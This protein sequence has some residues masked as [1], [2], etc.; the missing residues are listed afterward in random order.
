MKSIFLFTIL[1]G[2]LFSIINA[3]PTVTFTAD[4]NSLK[5]GTPFNV[6]CKVENV[7][8]KSV[9]GMTVIYMMNAKNPATPET[10]VPT[11]LGTWL[12]MNATGKLY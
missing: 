9:T 10:P 7:D 2:L 4:P 12:Y 1:S 3:D 6:N 11:P 8:F 5:V